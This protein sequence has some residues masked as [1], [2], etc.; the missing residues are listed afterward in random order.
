MPAASRHRGLTRVRAFCAAAA[1]ATAAGACAGPATPTAPGQPSAST[2]VASPGSPG[3]SR[4]VPTPV[5]SN[6][7]ATA[8][9]APSIPPGATWAR[10][11]IGG[12]RPAAREDHTWTVDEAGR[13]AYLFGGRDGA[14]DFDD[15]WAFDLASDTWQRINPTGDAPPARFGHEAAWVAGRGLVL[16]GGQTGA[17]FYD[18]VWLFRPSAN[19]WLLLPADGSVPIA[20]YGSCSGVASDGRFWISHGFT[21]DGAR[22]AD[23]LA[24]DFNAHEW[25]TQSPL[26]AGPVER[27]LHACWW[28]A[29]DRFVLYGGQTTGVP[30]LGDLWALTPGASSGLNAWAE[31][32]SP[33]PPARQLAAVARRGL[34][35]FIVGGRGTDRKPLADAWVLPDV[36]PTAFTRLQTTGDEPPARS[37]AA[38]IYDA[39]ADRML[40]FGGL[41]DDGFDDLWSLRFP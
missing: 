11:E 21:A 8:L 19:E 36:G 20:R 22:F 26:N 12:E 25:T 23:T 38:M 18:D 9:V 32:P 13:T 30:A 40:L 33:E 3:P 10:I 2:N 41:G 4:P 5:P 24:Y 28:T 17:S 34:L 35:T 6:P 1:L 14:T 39:A 31:A 16:F 7:A 15:L 27:C 29:D 37:G